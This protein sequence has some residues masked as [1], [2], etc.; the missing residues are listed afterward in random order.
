MFRNIS[1]LINLLSNLDISADEFLL[2]YLIHTGNQ[3]GLYKFVIERFLKNHKSK[4]VTFNKDNVPIL[5][6][7][8]FTKETFIRLK[9]KG[10][11][12]FNEDTV[13]QMVFSNELS[14]TK[15]FSEYLFTNSL[16]GGDELFEAYPDFIEINGKRMGAKVCS[17]TNIFDVQE[18]YL[19]LIGHN[20]E[21]H[22]EILKKIGI[23]KRNKN[24]Y[25]NISIVNFVNQEC[26]K[27]LDTKSDNYER[28]KL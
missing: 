2:L 26:W 25:V 9:S 12:E 21:K 17:G 10:Y 28:F 4:I 22:E 8:P 20:R 14:V 7:T 1:H 27:Y 5:N 6:K 11:I 15:E 23:A 19:E 18:T 24:P 3:D 16:E 13:E